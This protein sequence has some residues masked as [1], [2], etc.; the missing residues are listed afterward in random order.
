M[1]LVQFTWKLQNGLDSKPPKN[2]ANP[3]LLYASPALFPSPV[4]PHNTPKVQPPWNTTVRALGTSSILKT[5]TLNQHDKTQTLPHCNIKNPPGLHFTV[6]ASGFLLAHSARVEGSI[7]LYPAHQSSQVKAHATSMSVLINPECL[8][9]W[10]QLSVGGDI[11][12]IYT[13]TCQWLIHMQHT[14]FSFFFLLSI[15]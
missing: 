7:A 2:S 1:L 12:I 5:Q 11:C 4:T 13:K 3:H 6:D 10:Q 14:F 8:I 15:A 9:E